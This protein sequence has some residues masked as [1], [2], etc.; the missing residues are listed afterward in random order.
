MFD[1]AMCSSKPPDLRMDISTELQ[2]FVGLL[3]WPKWLAIS[4]QD[5]LSEVSS[6]M[7]PNSQYR[8]IQAV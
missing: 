2:S 8:I 7:S 6:A 3:S 5:C 4:L 1:F